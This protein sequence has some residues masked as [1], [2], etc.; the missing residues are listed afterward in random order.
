MSSL[1]HTHLSHATAV[2][3]AHARRSVLLL[4][5]GHSGRVGSVLC[6]LLAAECARLKQD[7]GVDFEI[8]G[9]VN[10][11]ETVWREPDS[12]WREDTL[13]R[14]GD[15][16]P[17]LIRRFHA[18]RGPKLFVDCTAAAEVAHHY[19]EFFRNGIGVVTPNKL[20]NS[21]SQQHYRALL[22]KARQQQV[23]Y[24]YETTVGAAL[25]LL[26]SLADLRA[27]GDRVQRIEAV[28]SGTL[29][30][31]FQRL[32]HDTPF[33]AAVREARDEG[34]TEPHPA[35]DLKAVDS[36][37]KLLIL[38]REA[39]FEWEPE[40][41][42]VQGLLPPALAVETDPERF[43]LQLAAYDEEW[44]MRAAAAKKRGL[45]LACLA[46]FDGR[47]A[48]VGLTHVAAGDPFAQLAPGENLVRIWSKC[49]QPVPLSISGPGAGPKITA[50]GLLTDIIKAGL[51]LYAA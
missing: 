38:L 40:R 12:A 43:L 7:T 32:N 42:T 50:A 27:A 21:G 48:R 18:L 14:S 23:P 44:A 49:Y 20:A 35:E 30:F 2:P 41:V 46:E 4:I 45:R 6:Q 10:R 11:R 1:E 24:L 3:L 34:Y 13:S 36:A 5:A 19:A 39:G 51:S 29:S 17:L 31:I 22:G 15:D 26:G 33:S 25:P 9:L 47:S 28:L 37:R 8:V 16:W